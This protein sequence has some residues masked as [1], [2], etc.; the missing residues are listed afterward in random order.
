MGIALRV[1]TPLRFITNLTL[2][3]LSSTNSEALL[4]TARSGSRSWSGTERYQHVG[5]L[6]ARN[7]T[8]T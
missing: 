1:S 2:P 8:C 3:E 6:E 7:L 5:T 4:S